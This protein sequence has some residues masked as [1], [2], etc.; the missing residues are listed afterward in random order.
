MGHWGFF[1]L[2]KEIAQLEAYKAT[3]KNEAEIAE[4][5]EVIAQLKSKNV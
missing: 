4:V 1:F 5:D 2:S 3:L